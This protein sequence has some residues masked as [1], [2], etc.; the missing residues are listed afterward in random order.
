MTLTEDLEKLKA[1]DPATYEQLRNY[2]IYVYEGQSSIT[3]DLIKSTNVNLRGAGIQD[4]I[5]RACEKQGW[6]WGFSVGGNYGAVVSKD[7][8]NYPLT[9]GASPAEAILAAY[10]AAKAK[11]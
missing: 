6:Y 11:A 9:H 4:V 2:P 1:I 7:M 8:Q 3:I 10:L 5:Q